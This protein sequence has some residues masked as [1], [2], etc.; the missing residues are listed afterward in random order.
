MAERQLPLP[1]PVVKKSN[2]L[3]RASWSVKSVYEPRLVALVASRVRIDDKDFQDYEIP[4][5]ELLGASSD[6]RTRQLVADVVDGLLGRVLTLPRANGWAKCNV[7]SCVEF[8]GKAGLIRARF[9]PSLKPHYLN[10]QSHFTEYALMEFLL[11]PSTYSQRLFEVL[12]SWAS[13]PEAV[14]SLSDLF[15]MLDVPDSLRANFKDFRRRVLEKAH[16]DIT[17]KTGLRFEWEAIKKGR[18]VDSIRFT[19]RRRAVVTEEKKTSERKNKDGEL[20]NRLLKDAVKCFRENGENCVSSESEQCKICLRLVKSAKPESTGI[21]SKISS[22]HK[23]LEKAVDK[24][25]T[26]KVNKDNALDHDLDKVFPDSD[27]LKKQMMECYSEHFQKCISDKGDICD[28]CKKTYSP[29]FEPDLYRLR[30]FGISLSDSSKV[31]LELT[32]SGNLSEALDMLPSLPA[33]YRKLSKKKKKGLP[34][35][36]LST[37]RLRFLEP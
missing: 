32:D 20:K 25:S 37:L 23:P 21:D 16:K 15:S 19:F 24:E 6:G 35:F 5:S 3:V 10:L 34:A 8:D 12:K 30:K 1:G 13:L 11:L 31:L 4:I 18:A 29:T 14:I 22:N 27:S 33:E 2:A 9:D 17:A 28:F 36:I 7:F 26:C